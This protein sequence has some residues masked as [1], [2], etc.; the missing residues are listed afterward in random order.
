MAAILY[1]PQCV[2]TDVEIDNMSETIHAHTN[3]LHLQLWVPD[4]WMLTEDH[5]GLLVHI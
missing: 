4:S 5:V 1:Q 2:I 3:S